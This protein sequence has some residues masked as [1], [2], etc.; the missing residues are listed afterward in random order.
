MTSKIMMT[1]RTVHPMA[2]G[3]AEQFKAG[4]LNRREY[5]ATMAGLG[6]TTAGAFALGGIAMP[7]AANAAE[8]K[9]GG[10]LRVSMQVK[11][12]KDPRTYDWTEMASAVSSVNEYFVRWNNDFSFSPWLL[13]SWEVSDD[14]KTYTL[15]AREG[16]KWS[17]G[18]DFNADDIIFNITR[19]CEKDVEGNSMA[20]RMAA[21]IDPDTNKVV[22]GAIE[23]IDERTVQLNLPRAD[24]SII[25]GMSDYPAQVMHRS[26]DGGNDPFA[27]FAISTGPCELVSY[28]VGVNAIVKRKDGDWWGGDF[29]LDEVEYIDHGTD[30]TAMIS[31]LESDEVDATYLTPP[32]VLE[33]LEAIGIQTSDKAT[34]ST[35]VIRMNADNAPYDDQRV[36]QA[37]QASVDNAIVLQL[38]INNTGVP[39]ANHHVGPMHIEYADVGPHV[40]DVEKAN[41]LLAEAGQSDFEFEIISIDDDWR[42]NTT[43]AV[44]A[45]MRDAGLKV[46][47]TVIPGSTFWNDWSKYPFSSTNWN[48]RPLGV[49]VLALAYKSGE[50]WNETAYSNPEFDGLLEQALATP[51]V[52]ARREIMAKL[53]TILRDSG[54]IIQPYWRSIFR[55][56]R[57]GV[58]GYDMHQAQFQFADLYWVDS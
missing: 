24:I 9:K 10:K 27:A 18:D 32:D 43:D 42:R 3:V 52:D 34:G 41:A 37:V 8:P 51:D 30:P 17:N 56:F 47:R 54:V 53:E 33:Q 48:G 7:S 31:A 49:Q 2:E 15:I 4:K 36:R 1:D 29:W 28:E 6:V 57:D 14:A 19:W 22:D 58:H 25:A 11:A 45:Q 23:K 50:A 21:M 16:V 44:A 55:S 35:I 26:Y 46:K 13:Q 20:G 39:A 5:L 12:W 40:R 38:G